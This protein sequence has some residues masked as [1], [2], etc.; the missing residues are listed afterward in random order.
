MAT[1]YPV[2][3]AVTLRPVWHQDPPR[4]RLGIGNNITEID[5]IETTTVH[6]DFVSAAD[7]ELNVEFLNKQDSD[8]VPEHG[9]DK[10]VVIES[11][12]FFGINDPKF[13]WAGAYTPDYPEPWATQQRSQGVVLKP[14]LNS[15]NY[16]SWNGK[17]RLTFSVPVF[18]WIH[19]T[20]NLG[21]IYG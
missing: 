3:L 15:H 12:S 20:Q 13:V 4:I 9:L 2:K 8:T 14:Q 16:L 6:F 1:Q 18:T 10:A 17:W 5:L 21:W 7:C 19:K 11:V